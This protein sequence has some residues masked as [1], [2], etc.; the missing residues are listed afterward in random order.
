MSEWI[1]FFSIEPFGP[2]ADDLRH[3]TLLSFLHNA[4][5]GKGGSAAR[6]EQFLLSR[7]DEQPEADNSDQLW[8][9]MKSLFKPKGK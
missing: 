6:I 1:A 4:L 2:I 8:N 5:R 9:Q 3:G 7:M